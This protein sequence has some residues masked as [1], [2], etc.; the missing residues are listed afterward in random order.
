MEKDSEK[1]VVVIAIVTAVITVVGGLVVIFFGLFASPRIGAIMTPLPPGRTGFVAVGATA[2]PPTTTPEIRVITEFSYALEPRTEMIKSADAIFAGQIIDISPT[3]YNQDSGEYWE[4]TTVEGPGLETTHTALPIFTIE[5]TVDTVWVDEVG[6]GETAVLT[7]VGYKPID[8]IDPVLSAGETAQPEISSDWQLQIGD[9]IIA[10]VVQREI[11]WWDGQPIRAVPYEDGFSFEVGRREVLRFAN[12]PL[13]TYLLRQEDGRYASPPGASEPWLP[14]TLDEFSHEIALFRPIQTDEGIT[15][16]IVTAVPSPTPAVCT[17]LPDGMTFT[18]T[19]T[20]DTAVALELTGLQP[21]ESLHFIFFWQGGSETSEIQLYDLPPV[22]D[23]GRFTDTINLQP[24]EAG[25][26]TWQIKA[27]HAW[28]VACT[29]ITLPEETTPPLAPQV[30]C[31]D[32]QIDDMV[33]TLVENANNTIYTNPVLGVELTASN[34]LCIHEP[35]YLFD[36]YGFTLSDPDVWEGVLMN[37]DWLYQIAPNQLEAY[38][39]Q[40]IDSYPELAVNRETI[41]INGIEGIMLWPLPGTDATTQIFLVANERPY[42]LIFWS[43]PLDEQAQTLLDGL[44]FVE[45][46]QSLESLDLPDAR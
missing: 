20:S 38:I 17:P 35:D 18:M 36:S 23:D 5:L 44:H 24:A 14:L 4:Q 25:A 11:A 16:Q 7:Q 8:V 43:A 12:A 22:G 45:P 34:K 3:Q 29:G 40:I 1:T 2:V 26:H 15:R 28:G 9:E 42:R 39:Q 13:D 30:I 21:G 32:P 27:I 46:T 41:T 37:V 33:G 6:L 31:P 19:P 10:F